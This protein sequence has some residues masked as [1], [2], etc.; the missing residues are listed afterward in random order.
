MSGL[1][2]R[3]LPRCQDQPVSLTSRQGIGELCGKNKWTIQT[4]K[5]AA[6]NRSSKAIGK[7]LAPSEA[8]SEANERLSLGP[9]QHGKAGAAR[10]MCWVPKGNY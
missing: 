10:L 6:P 5:V 7:I 9:G 8:Q 4:V 1:N 3:M 2:Q